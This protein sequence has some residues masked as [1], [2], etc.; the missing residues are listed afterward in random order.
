[1]IANATAA[2]TNG[3]ANIR[4]PAQSPRIFDQGRGQ[5]NAFSHHSRDRSELPT[6]MRGHESTKTTA[7]IMIGAARRMQVLPQRVGA[8]ATALPRRRTSASAAFRCS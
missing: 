4:A 3:I 5:P 2:A 1:V 7:A 8:N 6:Q